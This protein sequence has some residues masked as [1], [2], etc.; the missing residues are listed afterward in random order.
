MWSI[1]FPPQETKD[2]YTLKIW[3]KLR[4]MFRSF[5]TCHQ[6]IS[7]AHLIGKIIPPP[8]GTTL[9]FSTGKSRARIQW[10]F[11]DKISDVISRAWSFESS[12][13]SIRER[14]ARIVNDATPNIVAKSLPGV[15]ILK[16]ATLILRN[17]N[18]TFNGTYYFELTLFRTTTSSVAVFITSKF[19]STLL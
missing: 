15:E 17:V 5:F 12:D 1:R 8:D 7:G 18:Q 19:S 14:L 2:T 11:D 6:C 13:G 4:R 16:P 9:Y 3:K 10:S